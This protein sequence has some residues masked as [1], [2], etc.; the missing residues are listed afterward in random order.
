MRGVP[1][2]P[3]VFVILAFVLGAC[4]SSAPQ[5]A[6][7]AA[8]GVATTTGSEAEP[9]PTSEATTEPEPLLEPGRDYVAVPRDRYVP[10]WKQPGKGRQPAFAFDARNDFDEPVPMLIERATRRDGQIWYQV[11]L[12]L[13]P[14][15]ATAWVRSEDVKIRER[16]DRLEVDLSSRTLRHYR[17]DELVERFDVGIGTEQYPTTTGRFYVY[18]KVPYEN[19]NQAYGIMALGLSGF[20]RVITDWPGGGRIAVHGTPSASDRGNAVSHGCV[21]VYND[22]MQRLTDLP[23][24]TPV[25]I[26]A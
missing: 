9:P 15:G 16:E 11:L 5:P 12:P 18:I 14:N 4:S 19:P 8:D 20:S 23:L 10:M 2:R 6:E 3:I 22:D 25:V 24:G 7:D 17:G 1:R 26:H 21:R 13:R